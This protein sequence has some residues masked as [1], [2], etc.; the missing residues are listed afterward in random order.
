MHIIR[1]GL[2]YNLELRWDGVRSLALAFANAEGKSGSHA[3]AANGCVS[4]E[5]SP[6]ISSS[7]NGFRRWMS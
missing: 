2:S 3:G 4:S 7:R 1:A 5:D 6:S